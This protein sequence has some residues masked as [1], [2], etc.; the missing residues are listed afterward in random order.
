[1]T[2]LYIRK[3]HFLF[4][5]LIVLLFFSCNSAKIDS[6]NLPD[7]EIIYNND[8]TELYEMEISYPYF[9][10]KEF[11]ILNQEVSKYINDQW[12]N[13]L[14]NYVAKTQ[15]ESFGLNNYYFDLKYEVYSSEDT[16]SVV[17]SLWTFVGGAHGNFVTKTFCFRYAD[18]KII[19]IQE[20]AAM[21]LT[22]ISDIC[23]EILLKELKKKDVN[24]TKDQ[25]FMDATSPINQN[26]SKF[27]VNNN[28]LTVIFDPYD[29]AAYS[30]GLNLVSFEI[31]KH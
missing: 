26:Y 3:F 9:K 14:V 16:V 25:W 18:E 8:V 31:Q 15:Y 19:D 24:Y 23:R 27:F 13:F 30:Y 7:Y 2:K 22:E 1:M 17:L 29:V 21:D 28:I 20:A 12:H 4:S 10:S 6:I 5:I 11:N